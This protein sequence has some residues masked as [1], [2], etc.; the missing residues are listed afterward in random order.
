[1][2]ASAQELQRLK[3][4]SDADVVAETVDVTGR[5]ARINR[6]TFGNW[7]AEHWQRQLAGLHPYIT[8]ARMLA[9]AVSKDGE[10]FEPE[11]PS[12]S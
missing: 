8:Q 7:T 10:L 4:T 5:T 3:R 1:M 6:Q 9:T 2:K 12:S 11:E